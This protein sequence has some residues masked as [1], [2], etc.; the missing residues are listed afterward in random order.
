MC[1]VEISVDKSNL[2]N[3]ITKYNDG[4]KT[5]IDAEFGRVKENLKAIKGPPY[6]AIKLYP[7]LMNTQGGPRRD[8]EARVLDPYGKPIPRLYEAGELGSI[9]SFVYQGANSLGEC[10]AFGR[11]A[12]KNA[13]GE[14][15]WS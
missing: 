9:W 3:T 1:E 14:N 4:C 2:E 11:I 15:P 13:A 8:K 5:G 12:G 6:Y 10:I 7:A